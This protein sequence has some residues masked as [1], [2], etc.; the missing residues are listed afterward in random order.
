M[1]I[2]TYIQQCIKQIKKTLHI[3]FKKITYYHKNEWQNKHGQCSSRVSE[4]SC[5][6]ARIKIVTFS[7]TLLKLLIRVQ[8]WNEPENNGWWEESIAVINCCLLTMH[9]KCNMDSSSQ[10]CMK[11]SMKLHLGQLK[12]TSL[13]RNFVPIRNLTLI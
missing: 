13:I 12:T 7:T 11:K 2:H 8:L 6:L 9:E 5:L 4:C 10:G 1:A 3:P